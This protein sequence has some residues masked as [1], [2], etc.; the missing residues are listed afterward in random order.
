MSD[1]FQSFQ[2]Y[3]PTGQEDLFQSAPTIRQDST[4]TRVTFKGGKVQEHQEASTDMG[5]SGQINPHHGQGN[6]QSTARTQSGRAVSEITPDTMV[7]MDGIT[8]K[9]S[10]WVSEGRLNKGTD[11]SYVEGAAPAQEQQVVEGDHSPIDAGSMD[12]INGALGPLP[13]SSLEMV[14]AQAIGVVLGRLD[15]DSLTNK[16]S[17]ASGLDLADSKS[18]V[19]AITAIYQANADNALATRS[20]IGAADK[21]AFWEWA[22]TNHGGQLQDAVNKQLRSHDVSGYKALADQWLSVTAPSLN[23]FKAAGVPTRNNGTGAEVF[24][25]GTWMSPTSAAR[26]GLI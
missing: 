25:K 21:A 2:S 13:D 5:H 10:F 8:A 24:L 4:V 14:T 6:W 11:G 19:T 1:N 3:V 7:E 15:P 18:R 23:S 12:I 17:Q 20:G 22:K 26:A 9:V 16:F